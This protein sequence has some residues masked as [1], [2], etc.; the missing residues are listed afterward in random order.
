LVY[1]PDAVDSTAP[2]AINNVHPIDGPPGKG[3]AILI[4]D[5]IAFANKKVGQFERTDPF[6]LDI[7]IRLREDKPYVNVPLLYN[8]DERSAGYELKL[9]NNVLS[10]NLR[11]T[12]PYDMIEV[13]MTSPLPTGVWVHVTATYDGS[14]RAAGARIYVNGKTVE[15]EVLHDRLTRSIIPTPR[16]GTYGWFMGLSFGRTFGAAEFNKGSVDELRVFTR[17]LTPVEVSYL[18]DPSSLN[19]FSLDTIRAQLSDVLVERDPGVVNARA[20]LKQAIKAEQAEYA[21]VPQIDVLGDRLKERPTYVLGRGNFDQHLQEVPVQALHRVFPWK[22]EYPGNRL[23]LA[24][25]LFDPDNP[26]T[27]RV[28]VNRL[29]QSHFG[30]GIV[31]T[32]DDFGVQGSI[33]TNPELLDYLA[34]EFER[35]G[36]NIKRMHKLIVI[37]AT[38]RQSSVMNPQSIEKDGRN[39]YL[40]RGPRYRLSAEV[41]RDN[42]LAASGLLVDRAGGDSVF[43]YQPKGVWNMTGFGNQAYPDES[44]VPADEMHRRSMYTYVKRNSEPPALAVFDFA[45]RNES[46]VV[47]KVSSTP[48]QALVL[49]NDPQF[50]E[51]YRKL[52]ERAVKS[53]SDVDQQ[54]VTLFRLATRRHP[55]DQELEALRRYRAS[56]FSSLKD[57]SQDAGAILKIGVTASDSS[58]DRVTLSVMTLVAAAVMNS[59]D[60]YSLR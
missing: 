5:T 13:T 46:S 50:M 49:L 32:V 52:A 14:S 30:T 12:A 6:T 29:W 41:I 44:S 20:A 16:P 43:P 24:K 11:N 59:P 37:S 9:D 33:P 4:D 7:W 35:S 57:S 1:T 23:G 8:S 36:W 26:L 31:E 15:T 10:F 28:Y 34:L 22:P 48:L 18:D 51:A 17:A 60:A 54:I 55:S 42:A 2:G 45:D 3:K 19:Y 53:S 58:V 25:W 47:R 38:Y 56:Q 21:R 40:A 27:A 39:T